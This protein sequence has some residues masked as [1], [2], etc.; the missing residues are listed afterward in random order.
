[1]LDPSKTQP[2][3]SKNVL[4]FSMVHTMTFG[5]IVWVM[6]SLNIPLNR[7]REVALAT[8]IGPPGTGL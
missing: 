2:S 3:L 7:A 1:M 6:V 4:R 5:T 8:I